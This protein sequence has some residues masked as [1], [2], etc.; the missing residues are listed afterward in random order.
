ML[1]N[2][3]PVLNSRLALPSAHGLRKARAWPPQ[4]IPGQES[5]F[6]TLCRVSVG[7]AARSKLPI[8]ESS[9]NWNREAAADRLTF[10]VFVT[11]Q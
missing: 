10:G 3:Q 8:R 4:T 2:A 6:A 11:Y 1:C 7:E 9:V 5:C